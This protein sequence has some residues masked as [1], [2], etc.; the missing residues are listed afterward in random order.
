[1]AT[2]SPRFRLGAATWAIIVAT[3]LIVVL[4]AVAIYL[5]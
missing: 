1:M 2:A 5:L 4:A 3:L